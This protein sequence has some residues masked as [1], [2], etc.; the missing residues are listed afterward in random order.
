[1][2]KTVILILCLNIF[3]ISQAQDIL[4]I[5]YSEM[6]KEINDENSESYY[7]KLLQR[8]NDFDSTLTI[9]EYAL[10]YYGFSFHENYMK[11]QSADKDIKKIAN[12]E[13][14]E[15]TITVCEQV[16]KINPVSL[17][18]NN[19]IGYA[20]FK[21]GKPESEWKKYQTRYRA[22]RKVIAMSGDGLSAKTAFKVIFVSDEY[23]MMY[24]YFEI[25]KI[26]SQALTNEACDRFKID[27]G[28]YYSNSE[29]Y[30]DISRK[31][32]KMQDLFKK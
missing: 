29:I 18:A 31:L 20:L 15:K 26:H 21:L 13:D 27:P 11:A 17:D 4:D 6:E 16:L 5:N 14:Y 22:I 24:S 2:R 19:E 7:P 28:E 25:S 8:Y 30:F 1:M 32:I 10:V 9:W 12:E 3:S 23:N